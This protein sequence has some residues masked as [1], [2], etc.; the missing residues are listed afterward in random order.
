MAATDNGAVDLRI[1]T[2]TAVDKAKR[3]ARVKFKDT[4]IVSGWLTVVQH[5]GAV[6]SVVSNG[7]H[8]HEVDGD[9]EVKDLRKTPVTWVDEEGVTHESYSTAHSHSASVTWWVPKINDTVICAYL[10]AFNADGYI[11]GGVGK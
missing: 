2:V 4:G 9:C 10:P 6:V 3:K 8:D 5:Y 11:L 1:G 7:S